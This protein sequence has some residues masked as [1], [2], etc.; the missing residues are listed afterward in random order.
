[1]L[2]TQAPPDRLTMPD[3]KEKSSVVGIL[4][5]AKAML[6]SED[7]WCQGIYKTVDGSRSCLGYTLFAGATS[8]A[9]YSDDDLLMA[10]KIVKEE[11]ATDSIPKWNDE[12]GRTFMDVERVLDAAIYRAKNS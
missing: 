8:Y 4:E 5:R 9:V 6:P 3:P 1:M 12:E 11:A 2:V 10:E 7:R